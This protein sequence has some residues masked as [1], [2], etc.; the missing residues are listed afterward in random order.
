[1]VLTYLLLNI[2]P[3]LATVTQRP[4]RGWPVMN[5]GGFPVHYIE[6]GSDPWD[7]GFMLT[8]FFC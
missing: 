7:V 3:L 8:D 5:D 6:L 1:M 4:R 2:S